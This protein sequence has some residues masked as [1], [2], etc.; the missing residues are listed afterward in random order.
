MNTEE[1]RKSI[2][3]G[4]Q[5]SIESVIIIRANHNKCI[6][7]KHCRIY[8]LCHYST[9]ETSS[10]FSV[11]QTVFIFATYTI[12]DSPLSQRYF[13]DICPVLK[14]FF[15]LIPQEKRIRCFPDAGMYRQYLLL[16]PAYVYIWKIEFNDPSCKVFC[17]LA[18]HFIWFHASD[19]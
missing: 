2:D 19:T 15:H 12:P 8:L 9:I 10:L 5:M 7:F 17:L 3:E 11:M 14:I 4:R 6:T 18:I 16:L 1:C 13:G